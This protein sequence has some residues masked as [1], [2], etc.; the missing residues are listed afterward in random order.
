MY[1][2]KMETDHSL[3][4]TVHSTIYQGD[5]NADTLVF[6]VPQAVDEVN[7]A[8][9]TLLLRYILPNG[10]GHSEELAMYPIPHNRDYLQFR[11]GVA[12]RFTEQPGNIELWLTA[13]DFNDDVVFRTGTAQVEIAQHV[14]IENY[15]PPESLDQLDKLSA[16]VAA[17]EKGRVNNLKY[18]EENDTLQLVNGEI[19][20][21]SRETAADSVL[22][23]DGQ[24]FQQKLDEGTLNGAPGKNGADGAPGKDGAAAGFGTP[25]AEVDE[26]TGVPSVDITADGADTEKVFHF[27]FHNL[28]GADGAPGKNG[29]NGA[30]GKD[31]AAGAPGTNGANGK[32][33]FSPTVATASVEGGTKVTITDASGP[34][35]FTV[36]NGKDGA[37]GKDG[38]PGGKGDKGEPGPN[39]V[40]TSTGTDITGLLKGEGGKVAQAVAGSDYVDPS[41]L[42]TRLGRSDNLAAAN[43]S[44][45]TYMARAIAAG[46]AAPSSLTNGCIYLVYE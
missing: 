46:T 17:L 31:G 5:K 38:A 7:M 12:S 4:T 44:Y 9:C 23:E 34:K 36:T 3:T 25:T 32:D 29:E 6:V 33:G 21:I 24:T 10:A 2:I 28:K 40:S 35:E 18:D 22:F 42:N 37:A 16:K 30:P 27:S 26:G 43:T 45:S 13:V 8:D 14:R 20:Q 15:M 41:G 1:A 39:K 11:L 19:V